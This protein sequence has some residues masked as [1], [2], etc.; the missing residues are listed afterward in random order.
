MALSKY[1]RGRQARM[2]VAERRERTAAHLR[3]L[4][5]A[6]EAGRRAA[7]AR[8]QAEGPEAEGPEGVRG[9]QGT[10]PF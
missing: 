9:T 10:L 5:K 4:A 2:S 3:M 1:E 7:A 8:P 6:K